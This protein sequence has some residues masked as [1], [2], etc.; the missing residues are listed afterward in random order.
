MRSR[1]RIIAVPLVVSLCALAS[2]SAPSVA[3]AAVSETVLALAGPLAQ[4]F[5]VPSE[6]VTGLLQK[7]LSLETVTQLLLVK[8][9]SGK[10]LDAVTK[11]YHE[12]GDS[13]QK[14]ADQLG[15]SPDVYSS[16]NVNASI[17]RAKSQAAAS[18]S[19]KASEKASEATGKAVDSLTGGLIKK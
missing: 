8:Q 2:A 16:K 4:S 14:A 3:R 15:V 12:K 1:S 19:Q 17:E 13:V 11:T 6:A 5:G 10:S 18:A 7:G 9:S